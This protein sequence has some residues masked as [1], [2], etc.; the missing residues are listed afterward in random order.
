MPQLHLFLYQKYGCVTTTCQQC[1]H[2]YISSWQCLY[3]STTSFIITTTSLLILSFVKTTY[4]LLFVIKTTASLHSSVMSDNLKTCYYCNNSFNLMTFV[5]AV[6]QQHLF[7]QINFS[8]ILISFKITIVIQR[9]VVLIVKGGFKQNKK[10]YIWAFGP[11]Q[12]GG[13]RGVERAQ[14]V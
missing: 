7:K 6:S 12:G 13:S 4:F 3:V 2:N 10:T 1:S 11:N 8:L 14:Y 5:A 9:S